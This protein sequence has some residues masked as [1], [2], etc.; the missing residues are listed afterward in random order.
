[1]LDKMSAEELTQGEASAIIGKKAA[2]AFVK[3]VVEGL[4]GDKPKTVKTLRK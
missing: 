4:G 1:M 2:D 3:P